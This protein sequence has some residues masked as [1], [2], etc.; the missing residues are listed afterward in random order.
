MCYQC[1][2]CTVVRCDWPA[3]RHNFYVWIVLQATHDLYGTLAEGLA[4]GRTMIEELYQDH[5]TRD[6]SA[7]VQGAADREGFGVQ[8]ITRIKQGNPV[9]RIREHGVH[10]CFLGAPYR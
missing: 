7:A 6:D 2:R 1:Y 5:L 10:A 3:K 9:A 8:L 4:Q